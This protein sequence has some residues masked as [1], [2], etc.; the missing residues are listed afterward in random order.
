MRRARIVRPREGKAN[1]IKGAAEAAPRRDQVCDTGQY[2][3]RKYFSEAV[4]AF[5]YGL[6]ALGIVV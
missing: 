2:F 3:N 5:V 6:V 1:K 4:G